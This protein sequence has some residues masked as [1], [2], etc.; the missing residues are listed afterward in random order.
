MT[1][2]HESHADKARAKVR[3]TVKK[4]TE[5]ENAL[6]RSAMAY[7]EALKNGDE[8]RCIS[9]LE[10][11]DIVRRKLRLYN[12]QLP[13]H[14]E[15]VDEAEKLDA[16][17]KIA[18]MCIEAQI[19]CDA[20]AQLIDAYMLACEQFKNATEELTHHSH[21]TNQAMITLKH[22]IQ[23]VGSTFRPAVT[24]ASF[25]K[26]MHVMEHARQPFAHFTECSLPSVEKR[27]P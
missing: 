14:Q 4:I 22:E 12:D 24:R 20:E 1:Q 21:E 5:C 13:L 23:R 10:Q 18:A 27:Q 9:E 7:A 17:P 15:A 26:P 19:L 6:G 3:D 8:N 25:N 16:T 2:T 11:Q